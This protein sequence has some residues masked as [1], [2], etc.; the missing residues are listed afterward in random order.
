MHMVRRRWSFLAAGALILGTLS[1]P[2]AFA[3][4]G[5]PLTDPIPEDPQLASFGLVVDELATFPKSEPTPAPTDPRLMRHARI[6]YLG[7][8]PDGSGRMY[9]PDLNG[10]L[11]L[12]KGKKP[13]PYLDVKAA[14][15]ADFFSGRGMG[16]GFGFVT[17]HP[18][19]K[20]NGRFYTV[21]TEAGAALTSKTPDLTT[22]PN[23]QYHSVVTE[24][25][26]RDPRANTFRGTSREILRLGYATQIHAIQQID[27][28]PTADR[29]D[30]DYGLLYIASGDGGIGVNG[31]EPQN[32]ATPQGKILRID[33]A[34]TNSD[35]GRYGIPR[36]NPFVGDEGAIGE[37]Y[38]YGMRDPHRFSWDRGGKHR[39][40]LGHIGEKDIEAIYDVKAGDNLGWS[41]REGT[42]TF[43]KSDPC[44]LYPLPADDDTFGYVYPVAQYDHNPPPGYPCGADVGRAVS[45]GFV[46]RGHDIP[47]LRGKYVF[48]DLVDGRVFYTEEKQMRR[49]KKPAKIH[50]LAIFD[51]RQETTMPVLA[52]D[53]RVDLRIGTDDDGE[54]Y[55]LS[56]ANGKI[57]TVEGT[58]QIKRG[59]SEIFPGLAGDVVAHYDFDDTRSRSATEQDQGPSGTDIQLINGGARMRVKDGAFPASKGSLQVKQVDPVHAGNDDWKA[60]IYSATGLESLNRFNAVKGTTVMGWIKMTGDGP[61]PNTVTPDPDD[62]YN[63]IGLAGILSG[64]SD[65]HGVR[66]LLE[67]IDVGG[68]LKLVAL[69]R[70]LDE[71][72]SQTF[73]ADEDWRTLL[74]RGTWVHIAAT[75]DFD[76][77]TMALYKNGKPIPGTYTVAGDPW[78]VEGPGEH[79]TSATNPRGI[80]IGG[81]FPQNDVERNPCNC[82]MDS[83]QFLDRSVAALEV[84][85]Q[86]RRALSVR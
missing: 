15:G 44:N 35:N 8:I 72:A 30:K 26:A 80:K 9:V 66:A 33:P 52:D 54:L 19:F 55:L 86:Y 34:G 82:R 12:L 60:G 2:T 16:S 3:E 63:A 13:Q 67:L 28:N 65:G 43:D 51:G 74:P 61:S 45:G 84:N 29:H 14:V 76:A 56:K 4:S 46:Y 83:L 75:F 53:R 57:W 85:Q 41:E 73:A 24:W 25:T 38:A 10:T 42:F 31:G 47:Q 81:S 5:G 48:A 1:V 64:N 21:H 62:R 32:L 50:E 18:R 22:Q 49:G 77:G 70:R 58:R 40:L 17:F 69:G 27:F 59:A 20:Q 36:S 79:V 37:I 68:E 23:T 78:E 6:N 11:Y 7:E 71:G 39:L